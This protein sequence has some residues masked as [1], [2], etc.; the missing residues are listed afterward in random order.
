MTIPI[1]NAA[2]AVFDI[3]GRAAVSIGPDR[4]NIS[5]KINRLVTSTTSS[6]TTQPQLRVY[7]NVET[8]SALVDSTYAANYDSSETNLL[9]GTGTRLLFIW[10]GGA[11]GATATIVLSGEIV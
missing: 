5:W 1:E 9:V 11:P 8:P 2:N 10:T 6:L 7:R 4:A 3:N